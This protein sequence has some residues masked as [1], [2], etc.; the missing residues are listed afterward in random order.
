LPV[1][2]FAERYTALPA[3][4]SARALLA[5]G[6]GAEADA[7]RE[8]EHL[9][10]HDFSDIPRDA[11]WMITMTNLAQV[12]AALRDRPRAERL[13]QLL[14]PCAE[15]CVI[16]PPA[17]L[18][19]GFVS[20]FLGRLAATLSR[21]EEA[22]AHFVAAL[23]RHQQLE[24]RPLIALTQQYYAVMLLAR[25]QPGDW[26]QGMALLDQVLV[27]A[28]ELGLDRL[29]ERALAHKTMHQHRTP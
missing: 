29:A 10:A 24:A 8:L 26:E 27:T 25:Q 15:L 16:V 5:I 11:S 22:E 19:L 18:C 28:Q 23:R 3:W 20:R 14:F 6:F 1:Q 2:D 13:Y 12:C 9:A 21:W 7:R 4:R 17:L